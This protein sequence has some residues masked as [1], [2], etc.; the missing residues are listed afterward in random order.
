MASSKAYTI[1]ACYSIYWWEFYSSP[2]KSIEC[3]CNCS[4]SEW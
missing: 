4:N 2:R 1:Q 3:P